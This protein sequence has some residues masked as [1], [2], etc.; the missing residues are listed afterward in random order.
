MAGFDHN[1]A[2]EI[3]ARRYPK[4]HFYIIDS[5]VDAPN[6]HSTLFKEHEGSFLAGALAALK[7]KTNV[8]GFVGGMDIPV[9]H[10]FECGYKQGA[11]YINPDIRLLS[12]II[13]EADGKTGW[14]NPKRANAI[15]T[16]QIKKHADVLFAAA[17]AS[18]KGVYNAAK[19]HKIYAIGVD[20]NQNYL[21]PGTMLTSVVKRVDVA[22]KRAFEQTAN[23]L[24]ASG[25]ET[26]GLAENGVDWALDKYNRSEISTDEENKIN[27]IRKKIITGDIKVHDFSTDNKCP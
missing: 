4:T 11:K 26:L 23:G 15:A 7:S 12:N 24:F 1:K 3:A 10:K 20:S 27:A 9:I 5:V 2:L 8:I 14:N 13:G 16:T 21:I 22:V 19:A 6:V 25:V 18:G 17:G